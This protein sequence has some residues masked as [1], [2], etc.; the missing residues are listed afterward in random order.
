MG[1]FF[2]GVWRE[3]G[4]IV[5]VS[6]GKIKF[7][8]G[9]PT[10]QLV[11][12]TDNGTYDESLIL[13]SVF[14]IFTKLARAGN[15]LAGHNI[16]RFDCPYLC[17]RGYINNIEL[18]ILLQIH[19]KKPWEVTTVDTSELWSFGAWQEGFTSLN[20]LVNVLGIPSPKDDINGSEVHGLYWSNTPDRISR[21][22]TYCEKDVIATIRVLLKLS[23]LPD[24]PDTSIYKK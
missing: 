20:L 17:K 16:K 2:V 6:M 1:I 7:I 21:I 15:R 4:R 19:D 18:P 14:D 24:L 22:S 3:F 23:N 11:S 10:A 12:Y 13:K 5:C 9:E 8:D